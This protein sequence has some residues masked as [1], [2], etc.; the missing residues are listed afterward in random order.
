MGDLT[1][2]FPWVRP[3][4]SFVSGYVLFNLLEIAVLELEI[5]V[6][7]VVEKIFAGKCISTGGY[8]N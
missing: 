5:V 7:G 4:K 2:Q 8:G 6:F 1:W 3:V